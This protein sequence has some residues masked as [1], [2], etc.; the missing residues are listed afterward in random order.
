MPNPTSTR[1]PT[2]VLSEENIAWLK[3]FPRPPRDNGIGLHFHL[4]LGDY[5]IGRTVKN[6]KS[7][8]ATWTRLYAQDEHQARRA[9][10]ACW[11][12]DIMP[13]LR[14]GKKV[15]EG[16]DPA[17]FVKA[18]T[19]IG[20]PPYVQVFNEPDNKR[21]WV[22]KRPSKWQGVFGRS[23]ARHAARVF[24]LGGMPGL[25]VLGKNAFDAA[26]DAVEEI[27]RSDIWEQAFFVQHNYGANHPPNYPYDEIH[28]A[29]FPGATIHNDHLAV[30]SFLEYASWMQE[31]LGKVL[32]IIGGEG[33]WL[34]G[35]EED[36]R[37]PKVEQ[38]VH[39][40]YH[41]ELFS[42]LQSG[43]LANGEPLP[44]Y[45][46]SITPWIAGSWDFAGQNW[47]DGIFGT[48]TQTVEAVQSLGQFTRRFSWSEDEPD[49]PPPDPDPDED[50]ARTGS[51]G[52]PPLRQ[53]EWIDDFNIE[54][55]RMEDRPDKP[56]GDVVYRLVDVFTTRDGKWDLDPGKPGS[57]SEWARDD[58]LKPS[59]AVDYFDDAGADHH[60]LARVLDLD[61]KPVTKANLVRYWPHG[62]EKLADP[63]YDKYIARTPKL[64]SGWA[65]HEIWQYY[66][67][68]KDEQGPWCWCPEGASDV[69]VGGG[70][71]FR[72][73]VSIF[74]VWQAVERQA[75]DEDE[76]GGDD[77][78]TG[79]GG[80]DTGT[81][82]GESGGDG[83]QGE[84]DT[85]GDD[86]AGEEE[87]E[88]EDEGEG[89]AAP[90]FETIRRRAWDALEI[91][92]NPEAAIGAYARLHNL[93]VPLTPEYDVGEFR[94]QGFVGGIVFVRIGQWDQTSHMPW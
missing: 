18:L 76:P 48:L 33:G 24:D 13:V 82:E 35:A 27:G 94:C 63:L 12:A 53:G 29:E 51:A 15:D 30:L 87:D 7:I 66:N 14:V 84:D 37:Y 64:R 65:N 46:F 77:G 36:K 17:P 44:D 83:D 28:Q 90:D 40:A 21:E 45:V 2:V 71:P 10:I 60:L 47:W 5:W 49:E 19:D 39:A 89:G 9:A 79:D 80:E 32:P 52:I 16:F 67:P 20:A 73:H 34:L 54:I 55:V 78:E 58:Y 61:G 8:N 22:D 72:W 59:G 62:L 70:L 68:S 38:D 69:I 93:G 88:E 85:G 23:W 75:E 81:G 11:E 6:L 92:F 1:P 26:V 50:P 25:Q 31:R 56:Q 4:D 41:K 43:V 86:D 57:V 91:P 42:W 3:T 74:A